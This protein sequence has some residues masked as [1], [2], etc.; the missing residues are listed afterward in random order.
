MILTVDGK[1]V[2][3]ATG[4]KPFDPEVPA[5]VFLHGAGMDH[6]VWALQTRYFAHHGRSVLAV[7][8]PGHGRSE[9]PPLGSV[10]E[11]ATWVIKLLDAAGAADA[12]IVGHSMGGAIALEVARLA[13]TRVRALALVGT[14][15]HMPVHP[16]LQ[17]LADAGDH[18]A[19]E[20]ITDWAL[21]KSS[22]LGGST[23]PGMWMAGGAE[24]LLEAAPAGVLGVDLHA[25]NAYG[26]AQAAAAE[27]SCPTLIL[28]GADDRMTPAKQGRKLGEMIAGAEVV[29]L[30]R[31]GHSLMTEQ[32]D[33][34]LDA[35]RTVV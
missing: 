8:L 35:L 13:P 34:T 9:G 12:A 25:S 23:S 18:L 20:L 30:P 17:A 29:V 1:P 31:S 4:G 28:L 32:P 3:A 19:F 22:H 27:V 15:P 33:A 5:V 24:R 26:G 10:E 11:M 6:T 2:F 21:G 7:D 14:A 16:D